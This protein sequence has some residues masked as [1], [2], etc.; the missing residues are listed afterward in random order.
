MKLD[1]VRTVGI[2]GDRNQGKTNYMFWLADKYKGE[3]QI[4]FYA[5][6]NK[7]LLKHLGYKWIH[8]LNELELLTNSIIFMDEL[9]KHIKFY[10]KRTSDD[11][12]EL[13]SVIAHNNNTLVFSTPMSQFIT[14]ALDVFIDG[15]AYVKIS[16]MA[17]LKN[18]SK[19]KRLLQEF[20]CERISKRTL[21]LKIGEML[22]IVDG[23]EDTNGLIKFPNMAI[24][25][26]WSSVN[27]TK[28][29]KEAKQMLKNPD[30]FP[31]KKCK[32]KPKKTLKKLEKTNTEEIK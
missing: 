6:P 3:R 21:R 32:K 23:Q 22:Q 19:S 4:V 20:S 26:D 29:S 10:Q 13:L 30:I 12:L 11:F 24:G 27:P 5:Y 17:T 28:L 2:L 25:K 16:D 7:Q 18:G 15:F 9:Q 8:T 14:K 31:K 1:E